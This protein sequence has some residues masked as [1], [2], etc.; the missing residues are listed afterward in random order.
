MSMTKF[1]L[2]NSKEIAYSAAFKL[3]AAESLQPTWLDFI[4]CL[5]FILT[6]SNALAQRD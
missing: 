4:I 6:M 1:L 3:P 2:F 5:C